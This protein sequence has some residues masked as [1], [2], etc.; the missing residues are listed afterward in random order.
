M[1]NEM[2]SILNKERKHMMNKHF[3][4]LNNIEIETQAQLTI[5]NENLDIIEAVRQIKRKSILRESLRQECFTNNL[6]QF[7]RTQKLNKTKRQM[8]D[9]HEQDA[10]LTQKI[11]EA[12]IDK[13]KL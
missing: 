12:Q 8:E 5:Q 3:K 13:Q 4:T 11:A 2:H 7:E 10:F 1:D 6:K 9:H